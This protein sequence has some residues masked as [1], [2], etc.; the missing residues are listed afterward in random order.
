VIKD[1]V[2]P[3]QLCRYYRLNRDHVAMADGWMHASSRGSEP[4]SK[5]K[6]QQLSTEVAKMT[7]TRR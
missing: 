1:N 5:A 2:S 3:I 6:P 4:H 7:K